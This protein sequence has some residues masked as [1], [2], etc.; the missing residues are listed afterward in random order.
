MG[1]KVRERGRLGSLLLFLFFKES[2]E[3]MPLVVQL[4]LKVLRMPWAFSQTAAGGPGPV[5][6]PSLHGHHV[7]VRE[8]SPPGEGLR[9]VFLGSYT[10]NWPAVHPWE[11]AA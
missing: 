1:D 2:S 3:K 8:T 9:S 10:E 6:L 11:P 4:G 5:L 7:R